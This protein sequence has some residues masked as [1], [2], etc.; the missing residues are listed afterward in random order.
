VTEWAYDHD[1]AKA[2]N[3]VERVDFF[4]FELRK[5]IHTATLAVIAI[6]A[7]HVGIAGATGAVLD[8]SLIELRNLL[9]RS[10]ADLRG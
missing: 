6:K 2:D 10:L 1:L 4:I 8:R 7:G 3:K 5:L 9:D